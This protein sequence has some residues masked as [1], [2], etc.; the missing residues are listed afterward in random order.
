MGISGIILIIFLFAVVLLIAGIIKKNK[1][2]K[3][4]STVAFVVS[5]GLFLLVWN[6][7]SYM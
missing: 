1:V 2:L 4:V 7:L 6:A 3:I 5:I